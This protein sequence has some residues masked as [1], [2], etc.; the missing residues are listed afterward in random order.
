[1]CNFKDCRRLCSY[2]MLYLNTRK[3][4]KIAKLGHGRCF[5]VNFALEKRRNEIINAQ[6]SSLRLVFQM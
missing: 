1:M 3:L 4:P 6:T 5:A 2:I